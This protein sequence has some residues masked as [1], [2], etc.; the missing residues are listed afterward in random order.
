MK[1]SKLP[2]LGSYG[3]LVENFDWE[4]PEA[5]AELKNVNLKSLVTIVKGNGSDN[6]KNLVKHAPGNL[7]RLQPFKLVVK[8]NTTNFLPLATDIEKQALNRVLNLS[9][10]DHAPG[11]HRVTGKK[12]DQGESIGIFGETVLNW[13]SNDFMNHTFTPLVMLY[14]A[15]NMSASA[16]SFVQTAD[17]YES[18]TESFKS[19]LNELVAI[20]VRNIQLIT[21]NVLPEDRAI[22]A[23][24]T[25]DTMRIPLVLD[26]PGGIRGLHYNAYMTKFEG[27]SQE[28]SDKILNKIKSEI[29]LPE[30]EFPWWWDDDN[31]LLLFDNSVTLHRRIF[32]EHVNINSRLA[33]RVG[34]RVTADYAGHEDYNGYLLPEFRS[35]KQEFINKLANPTW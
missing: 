28:D 12:N 34:Y 18:Q 22:G 14:G 7:Y 11:W 19:E 24:D 5:Y 35:I 26:S 30:N 15:E 31:T 9:L 8:Y 1:V 25:P 32:R 23:L 21:P 4:Q 10:G 3:A 17:W 29:F 6:F 16:T 27:M 20:C 13:H 33:E 2:G